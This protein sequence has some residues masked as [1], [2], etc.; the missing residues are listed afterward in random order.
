MRLQRAAGRCCVDREATVRGIT[1]HP[2]HIRFK[3]N[4][5]PPFPSQLEHLAAPTLPVHS[6]SGAIIMMEPDH[7]DSGAL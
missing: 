4:T 1:C 3:L 7:Y 5:H 2:S 6:I